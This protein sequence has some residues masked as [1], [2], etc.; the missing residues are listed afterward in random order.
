MYA[1][2]WH[3]CGSGNGQDAPGYARLA[4]LEYTGR[5]RMKVPKR[6]KIGEGTGMKSDE[7]R[8]LQAPLKQRYRAE[9]D[10]ALI[11]LHAEGRLGEG[12][13]CKVETG[14]ALVEAG[15]H[16]ATGGNGF[17]AC[18]GDM[19]LEALVACAG[20]TLTSVATAIGVE[21]RDGVVRAEGL[22]DF[23]GTL[24]IGENVPVGFQRI[25]L[26][27]DL[28]TDATDEEIAK[29][30]RLT[31]RYCVVYQTLRTPPEIQVTPLRASGN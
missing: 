16:P 31:E 7:L 27:F 15:L 14:K 20:V 24:S 4:G 9:P 22:L 11:T 8:A 1:R 25:D 23:R 6:M 26:R 19:L 2:D 3:G 30:I 18:S 13:T 28:D 5:K 10:A 21:V 12:I 29:L 17:F